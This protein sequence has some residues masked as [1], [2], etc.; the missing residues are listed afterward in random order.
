MASLKPIE[1]VLQDLECMESEL[2]G[3]TL[4]QKVYNTHVNSLLKDQ[5]MQSGIYGELNKRVFWGQNHI[6]L[7]D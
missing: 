3:P 4:S 7:E 1:K 2:Q 5:H 6:F